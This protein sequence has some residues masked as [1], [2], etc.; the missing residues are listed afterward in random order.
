M[1]EKMVGWRF[2]QHM[3]AREIAILA[4]CSESTVYDVL[5][6]HRDYGQ[7]NNPFARTKGRARIL[8][9]ADI[10]YIHAL[11]QANPSLYLD[12]LQEQLL[13]AR[14]VDISIATISRTLRNIALSHKQ[15]TKKAAERNEHLRATW[16]AQ[17]GHIPAEYFIWI[18]EAGVDDKTNQRDSGWA[19]LGR[20]CVRRATFIRGQK[21]SVLPALTS[22][23]IIALD[24]FEGSVNKDR[25]LRFLERDLVNSSRY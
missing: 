18:D 7:V 1:R 8:S 23:G 16:Q 17:W 19:Q 24:I 22:D 3:T 15:V 4:G 21:Y 10:H 13:A 20:A 25:F 11:L 2:E 14:D 6:L 9:Q 12:E 5:R